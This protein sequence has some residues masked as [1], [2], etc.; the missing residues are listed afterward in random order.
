MSARTPFD[1]EELK[2]VYLSAYNLYSSGATKDGAPRGSLSK[3]AKG[4]LAVAAFAAAPPQPEP[5]R[6]W[7]T[8]G[9]DRFTIEKTTDKSGFAE[10]ILCVSADKEAITYRGTKY[11]KAM[12]QPEP[13][14]QPL[15][16]KVLAWLG[17]W[18]DK[19][20]PEAVSGLQD[21]LQ[22]PTNAAPEQAG[23]DTPCKSEA[24][25]E[26]LRS[27][28]APVAAPLFE[29]ELLKP[30][31]VLKTAAPNPNDGMF[32]MP[33]EYRN[34]AATQVAPKGDSPAQ[35]PREED[36]K[37]SG[38]ASAV[39]P[40]NP[41]NLSAAAPGA[42]TFSG[43]LG[44]RAASTLPLLGTFQWAQGVVDAEGYAG[45]KVL[46]CASGGGLCL[47]QAKQVLV[48]VSHD[49]DPFMFLH[50]IAHIKHNGHDAL[51]AD[52]FTKLCLQYVGPVINERNS[53]ALRAIE[54]EQQVKELAAAKIDLL[55]ADKA[56]NDG[57]ALI[58][59][60]MAKFAAAQTKLRAQ[61]GLTRIAEKERDQLKDKLARFET[62]KMPEDKVCSEFTD[63]LNEPPQYEDKYMV[64]EY[65][66]EAYPKWVL[67][68]E[69]IKTL[70]TFAAAQTVRADENEPYARRYRWLRER[71]SG[72][73]MKYRDF[74]E[75]QVG[76]PV[77]IFS[78]TD[79]WPF[80]FDYELAANLLDDAIDAAIAEPKT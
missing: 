47:Y 41:P 52:Y 60:L 57:E 4:L 76:H 65:R 30:Q 55:L 58:N 9:H 5:F 16:W 63:F 31:T 18:R 26:S 59:S 29:D 56:V 20:P 44:E 53:Q 35:E 70:C 51:W 50:E 36:G 42:F 54:L 39:A 46:G 74:G 8:D 15:E 28:P 73:D 14:D 17:H 72:A 61:E 34:A 71:Y 78:V 32:G 1:V 25:P 23:L 7:A 22:V 11:V 69:Y 62:A 12:P 37:C 24:Q 19:M 38:P 6:D 66:H 80:S 49:Q 77:A 45:W 64:R 21:I 33:S 79:P 67:V 3:H 27:E 13:A 43:T 48:D 2:R 68:C 40:D 10:E 75:G